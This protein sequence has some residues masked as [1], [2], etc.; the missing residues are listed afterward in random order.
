LTSGVGGNYRLLNLA[1]AQSIQKEYCMAKKAAKTESL[2]ERIRRMREDQKIDLD[3]LAHKTGYAPEYLQEIEEGKAA[4]PVG[5]LIQISRALQIDSSSL[6]AEA[7]K[8][9][10]RQG[11]QKR[12]KS[13]S[14]QNLT[15]EAED[16]H[17]WAYL[18]TLDP[19]KAHE[20]VAY[21]H[22]GEEF[23]YCLDGEA[24]IQVGGAPTVLKPGESLHFNSAVEHD[25]KNLSD[26]ETKLLV[27]VYAP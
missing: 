9:E 4:P 27:V 10:R 5:A 26:S 16:K 6:L 7:K 8:K 21:Q 22:E 24:E 11:Y 13:Y 3:A 18:I 19:K 1:P 12:T 15:P 20:R 25:L 17:L 23:V 2:G 14:Y